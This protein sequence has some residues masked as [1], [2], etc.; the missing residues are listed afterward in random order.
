MTELATTGIWMVNPTMEVEFIEAWTAFATWASGMPG[1]GP[2]RL[3]RDTGDPLRFVSFGAWESAESVRTWKSQPE[4]RARIAQVLQF[5]DDFHPSEL[6]VVAAC[7]SGTGAS[8]R[9]MRA[10]I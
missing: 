5:V 7:V 9:A 2:L 8:A 3:G 10:G 4:F 1:A 6:D